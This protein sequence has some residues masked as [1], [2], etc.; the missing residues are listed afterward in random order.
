MS[1]ADFKARQ[2]RVNQIINSGS[3]ASSPLLVYGL[4][5]ATN[6]S[7]GFNVSHFVTGSDTWLFVSGVAGSKNSSDRGVVTFKGDVVI[8][9]TIYDSSGIAYSAGGGGGVGSGNWNELSPSPRLN[10]TASVAIAGALGTSYA[11]QSA[12]TDTFFFVSGTVGLSGASA[13]KARFGGDVVAMG[14]LSVTSDVAVDGGNI[15]SAASTFN[16]LNSATTLNV[17]VSSSTINIGSGTIN[18]GRVTTSSINIGSNGSTVSINSKQNGLNLFESGAQYLK[19]STSGG[20]SAQI[21]ATE[22]NFPSLYLSGASVHV[23]SYSGVTWFDSNSNSGLAIDVT[24]ASNPVIVSKLPSGTPQSL[25]LSASN[26]SINTTSGGKVS[27]NCKTEV[28]GNLT[29][30]GDVAVDGGDITSTQSS[31]TIFSTN[32]TTLALANAAT[33]VSVGGS[34]SSTAFTLSVAANRTGG[35]IVNLGTGATSTGNVK[36]INI[37]QGGDLGSTTNIK[38]GTTDSAGTTN[39]YVSGSS[40]VTGSV[41]IK[42]SIV[43]DANTTYTLGTSALRWAH[44]Y[45]GDL[46]LRN[47]RG[48]WT[49]I[50]ENDFLRIVNNKTGKN[51]K[52]LM[53]LIDD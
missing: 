21:T 25:F 32:V 8:S 38:I 39:V 36:A 12:G 40:F 27:I 43:P 22:T 16:L 2:L 24:D 51:Y 50:E 3:R 6:N 5:S 28:T 33:S 15:T 35:S 10:T 23:D 47:E 26:I 49:V 7:G 44:V 45:T 17:G 20:T 52:M 14:S 34:S 46:H 18:I 48:D 19:F 53:Q 41:S 29:V 11:A 4:A 30:T 9:G 31:A 1:T 13:R 37:G 42:G